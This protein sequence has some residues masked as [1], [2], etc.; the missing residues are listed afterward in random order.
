MFV[1]DFVAKW[2]HLFV[3]KCVYWWWSVFFALHVHDDFLMYI[4][5]R[6]ACRNVGSEKLAGRGCTCVQFLSG[7]LWGAHIPVNVLPKV[8]A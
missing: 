8:A 1:G 6:H 2:P 7:L 5:Y 4:C 3:I